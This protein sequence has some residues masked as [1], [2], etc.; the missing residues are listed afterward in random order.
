[1]FWRKIW[2]GEENWKKYGKSEI[3]VIAIIISLIEI[4]NRGV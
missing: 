4:T 1:M 2:Y 3:K